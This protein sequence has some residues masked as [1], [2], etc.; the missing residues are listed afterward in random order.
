MLCGW[1]SE[2]PPLQNQPN[3]EK[4]K[5]PHGSSRQR[6]EITQLIGAMETFSGI[7]GACRKSIS[8]AIAF[9]TALFVLTPETASDSIEWS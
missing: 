6:V 9:Q 2:T 8:V 1:Q 4:F 3:L 5:I 7:G